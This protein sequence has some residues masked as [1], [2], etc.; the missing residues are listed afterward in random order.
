MLTFFSW[1]LEDLGEQSIIQTF[2]NQ[3][4]ALLQLSIRRPTTAIKPFAINYSSFFI[5]ALL[6]LRKQSIIQTF[7][8]KLFTLFHWGT[9]GTARAIHHSK[10]FNQSLTLLQLGTR[11]PIAEINH[12]KLFQS[13]TQPSSARHWRPRRAINHLNLF[14]INHSNLFNQSFTLTLEDLRQQSFKPFPINCSPFFSWALKDVVEQSIIQNFSNQ[15]FALLLQGAE[16]PTSSRTNDSN[17]SFK[18]FQSIIHHSSAGHW[19]TYE[20]NQS[21]K[22]FS[23][24]LFTILKFGAERPRRAIN[25]SNIFNQSFTLLRMGTW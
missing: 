19:R 15:L 14:L 4:F 3:S 22:L 25:L 11:G 6:D 18:P 20:S 5:W 21:F 8:I 1:A 23:N 7:S 12:S 2:S 17:Q 10:L 24:Q 9:H 16:T 13:I